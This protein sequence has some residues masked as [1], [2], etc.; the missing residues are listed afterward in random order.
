MH[1]LVWLSM[2]NQIQS[3]YPSVG[4][5]MRKRTC[6]S[7]KHGLPGLTE[8]CVELVVSVAY[9]HEKATGIGWELTCSFIVSAQHMVETFNDSV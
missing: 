5:D 2:P 6:F 9:D 1:L 4:S 8:S 3:S 7:G